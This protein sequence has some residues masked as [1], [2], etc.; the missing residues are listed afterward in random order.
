MRNKC[1]S[2]LSIA[3]DFRIRRYGGPHPK[4][5]E[6]SS[7]KSERKPTVV[8]SSVEKVAVVV[9]SV[10]NVAVVVS[11]VEYVAVVVSSVEYVVFSVVEYLRPVSKTL[12]IQKR[13]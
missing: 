4:T 3:K 8:V 9:S 2:S 7:L 13:G 5:K 1:R 12:H 11:S 6:I 10:E